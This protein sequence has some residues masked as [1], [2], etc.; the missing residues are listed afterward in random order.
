MRRHFVSCW[1]SQFHLSRERKIYRKH[2]ES[3]LSLETT[4]FGALHLGG[5]SK[6]VS[7]GAG[8]VDLVSSKS[9]WGFRDPPAP[10]L[11]G[12]VITSRRQAAPQQE[13][14][15]LPSWRRAKAERR[16]VFWSGEGGKPPCLLGRKG[17]HGSFILYENTFSRTT[18]TIWRVRFE[19]PALYSSLSRTL[20]HT[21]WHNAAADSVS[22][23]FSLTVFLNDYSC[24]SCFVW[25]SV[26]DMVS[27]YPRGQVSWLWDL[28]SCEM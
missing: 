5:V 15:H 24:C 17:M 27:V 25:S 22:F 16:A 18:G 12:T 6:G 19:P 14:S 26:L 11:W 13:P 20:V 10:I 1:D 2:W 28:L 3:F 7:C 23:D 4:L 21:G 8:F 9:W